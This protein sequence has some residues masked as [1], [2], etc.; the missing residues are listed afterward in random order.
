M[1]RPE[2]QDIYTRTT[3]QIVSYLKKESGLGLGRGTPNM[4]QDGLPAH[5]AT[6]GSPTAVFLAGNWSLR[7]LIRS[8]AGR[9]SG[10]DRENSICREE[11]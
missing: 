5:F 2:R 11:R 4:P 9:C 8:G 7:E 6:M 1:Q 10:E 3:N